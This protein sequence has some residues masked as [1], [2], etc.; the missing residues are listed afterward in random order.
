M[1][2]LLTLL[3]SS[4]IFSNVCF[5]FLT[6]S[7]CFSLGSFFWSI[8]K[9]DN[10]LCGCVILLMSLLMAFRSRDFSLLFAYC[11]LP[12]YT[13]LSLFSEDFSSVNN[14]YWFYIIPQVWEESW[15]GRHGAELSSLSWDKV[16]EVPFGK[17]LPHGYQ[18]FLGRQ[19]SLDRATWGAFACIHH[20]NG[21]GFL[22]R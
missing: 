13:N 8:C 4:Q 5:M 16:P 3:H 7:M 11:A 6:F 22:K 17:V 19:T 2:H 14:G 21:V 20:E 9:L 15:T 1:L 10:Y 12:G 18:P